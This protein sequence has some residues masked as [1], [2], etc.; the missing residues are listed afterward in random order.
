MK[1]LP[2]TLHRKYLRLLTTFVLSLLT[3]S[4]SM[5]Q[6]SGSHL[7]A[8]SGN[9][10]PPNFQILR[11]S[12]WQSIE[13]S[14]DRG[15][16]WLVG[17]Q[18]RDGSYPGPPLEQA[19]ISSLA[20]MAIISRGHIPGIGAEGEAIN[21]TIDFVL[22][23]QKP[24]GL[25]CAR[26][27]DFKLPY[28]GPNGI[29]YSHA[30]AGLFLCEVYGMTTPERSKRIETAV[31]KA[32][33][34]MRMRQQRP[35][36]QQREELDRG[37]WRYLRPD[38]AGGYYSDLSITSWMVMFMRSAENAGF[39]VPVLWAESS[40]EFVRRCYDPKSGGFH[41]V[42]HHPEQ[43]TRAMTAAGVVC[44]FLTGNGDENME[45]S[46]GKFLRRYPF[47]E[48][49]QGMNSH[50]RYFYSSYYCSQAALQLGGE[51][52]AVI[53]PSISRTLVKHQ[54]PQGNWPTEQRDA[55]TG[56]V[57]STTMALLALTPPYQLL[58]IYQR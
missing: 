50:D 47:D 9:D 2:I 19:G 28:L 29:M 41:Y 40:L 56:N 54:R 26:M 24:S 33:Q 7:H 10:N 14:V 17:Q 22:N 55:W 16:G 53:Y 36:P 25:L 1:P 12:E 51:T 21:R 31:G 42:L 23:V 11:P 15:I 27:E 58:P 48:F 18:N 52:W 5:A 32:L 30:I 4:T 20:A 34:Y 38:M 45:A 3:L 46:A 57:Y 44:L 35:L 6:S 43:I 37:G 39:D 8:K 49:N 13:A